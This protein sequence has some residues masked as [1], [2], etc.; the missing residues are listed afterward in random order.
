MCTV[1]GLSELMN[2][3]AVRMDGL[4]RGRRLWCIEGLLHS[5]IGEGKALHSLSDTP[6]GNKLFGSPMLP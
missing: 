6:G 4:V 1:V 3:F 5:V 2:V